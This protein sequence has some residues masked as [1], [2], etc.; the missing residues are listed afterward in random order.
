MQICQSERRKEES[1][2]GR[3]TMWGKRSV[4][5]TLHQHLRKISHADLQEILILRQMLLDLPVEVGQ[6]S[7]HLLPRV[8]RQYLA[9]QNSYSGHLAAYNGFLCI[10][11]GGRNSFFFFTNKQLS[12][13]Q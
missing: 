10:S 6:S 9:G 5:E 11:A 7:L 8:G 1:E 13:N 12:L 2:L 4:I 3:G